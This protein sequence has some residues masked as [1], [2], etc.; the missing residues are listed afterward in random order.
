MLKKVSDTMQLKETQDK[1]DIL[2]LLMIHEREKQIELLETENAGL[3]RLV[4]ELSSEN[5]HLEK[6]VNKLKSKRNGGTNE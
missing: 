5:K 3:K 2:I 4:V 1:E 6:V